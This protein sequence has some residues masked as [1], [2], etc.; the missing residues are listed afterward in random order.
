[1]C[2]LIL[3]TT[4]TIFIN[5]AWAKVGSDTYVYMTLVHPKP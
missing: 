4:L 2:R 5:L 1:M 3:I